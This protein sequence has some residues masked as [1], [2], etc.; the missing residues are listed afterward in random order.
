MKRDGA[1][2]LV[3]ERFQARGDCCG[4]SLGRI[5]CLRQRDISTGTAYYTEAMP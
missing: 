2:P 3:P 5:G 4:V 1:N